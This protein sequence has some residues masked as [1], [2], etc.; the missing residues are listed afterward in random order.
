[1]INIVFNVRIVFVYHQR[2]DRV[3]SI[4]FHTATMDDD[5]TRRLL[6]AESEFL[7][8]LESGSQMLASYNRT[9]SALPEILHTASKTGSVRNETL[10]L[11]HSVASRIA[12]LA[13]CF[14]D[15]RR[16]EESSTTSLQ[17]DCDTMIHQMATLDLNTSP[18]SWKPD[19]TNDTRFSR[20]YS[21]TPSLNADSSSP[22]LASAHQW[23]V[24]NLHN[25]Y[26]AAEV[27]AQMA[28]ASSCQV[29][30]VNTWFVNARRRI[31]WTTL[32]RER[33]SNCR[34][35]MIDA[36]YRALVKEDPQRALSPELRHS[37]IAMKVAAEGLYSSTFTRSAFAGDL[38]AIVR[39]MTQED[40]KSVGVGKSTQVDKPKVCETEELRGSLVTEREYLQAVRDSYPSPD[41]STTASPIPALDDSFTDES[42]E[43]EDVAPP[44]VAGSKRRRSSMEPVDQPSSTASR[45]IKRLRCVFP[46]F[47]SQIGV[48]D[49]LFA[50]LP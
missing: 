45:P 10:Y 17:R 50:A 34:A 43:E 31:G 14:L 48:H 32:C 5:L 19:D 26:P 3:L 44:I 4:G 30:S 9:W 11:A 39:D 24:D 47:A 42:E 27:K 29:S 41:P 2:K 22:F 33:F 25:P 38:D 15:I 7:T 37:F 13:S 20:S 1:M 16:G 36:A 8:A 21:S 49:F 35:D 12:N 6:F 23:L 18:K 28:V 40:T 46:R